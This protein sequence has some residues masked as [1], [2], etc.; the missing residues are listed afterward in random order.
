[1]SQFV[2]EPTSLDNILDIVLSNDINAMHDVKTLDTFSTSDHCSV[3]FRRISSSMS[4][5]EAVSYYDFNR[6][7]WDTFYIIA[8]LNFY[9]ATILALLK[10]LTC[11]ILSFISV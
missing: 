11:V 8:I 5:C 6:A 9:A 7:D 2:S 4:Y 1:M 3:S 10:S